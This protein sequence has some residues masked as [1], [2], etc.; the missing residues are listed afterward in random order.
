MLHTQT[1]GT[2]LLW[3]SHSGHRAVVELLIGNGA[4]TN[5]ANEVIF[6]G[7]RIMFTCL[8]GVGSCVVDCH[9]PTPLVVHYK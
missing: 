2:S 3:A 8:Y 5:I 4:D 1:G 9:R 7:V 6:F